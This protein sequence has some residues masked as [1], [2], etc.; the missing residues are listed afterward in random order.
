MV[1]FVI[2]IG[3]SH[4]HGGLGAGIHK[5]HAHAGGG[6]GKGV[7]HERLAIGVY[8]AE[9]HM[10]SRA[11]VIVLALNQNHVLLLYIGVEEVGVEGMACYIHLHAIDGLAAVV[12]PAASRSPSAPENT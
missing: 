11:G 2:E 3:V 6:G 8:H 7:L 4:A 10:R 12:L 9:L 1:E 5:P